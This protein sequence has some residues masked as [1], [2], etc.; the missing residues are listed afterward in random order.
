VLQEFRQPAL[1]EEFIDGRD[2]SVS[3]LWRTQS[4]IVSLPV[5]EIVFELP[6]GVPH[7]VGYEA[8][9]I[10]SSP[11]YA[12]TPQRCPASLDP[13]LQEGI[14]DIA[15][16]VAHVLGLRDYAR[17]DF[18][19]RESDGSLFVL[20]ANPNPDLSEHAGFMGAARASGRTA[21]ETIVEILNR[22]IERIAS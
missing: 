7:I 14:S 8:K 12:G 22:A 19:L 20:E 6:E 21:D 17:I 1:A 2:L 16:R 15:I 18:R 5:S 3:L 10:E 4:E 13:I 11:L 9:W